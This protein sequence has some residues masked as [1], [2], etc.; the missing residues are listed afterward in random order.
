MGDDQT[1]DYVYKFISTEKYVE[2]NQRANANL[3]DSGKLYVA[4]FNNGATTGDFMGTGAWVE[5]KLSDIP[6]S[7]T[8]YKF[9]N[10]AD[11]FDPDKTTAG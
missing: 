6:S 3:L 9:A 11:V 4:K 10:Q 2:G 5:L 1:D 7:Y 8:T